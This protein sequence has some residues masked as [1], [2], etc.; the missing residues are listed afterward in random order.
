MDGC[1]DRTPKFV[2]EF[3]K[4]HTAV[5]SVSHPTRLGKGG[6][7]LL[8]ISGAMGSIIAVVDADCAVPPHDVGRR[9][10]E[11]FSAGDMMGAG[12]TLR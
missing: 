7:I 4:N 11:N 10:G 3:S 5:R 12:Q 6:G 8:G 1:T 9:F 2:A